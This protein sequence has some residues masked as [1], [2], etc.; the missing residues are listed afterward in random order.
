MDHE[1]TP[2]ITYRDWFKPIKGHTWDQC[3]TKMCNYYTLRDNQQCP[4]CSVIQSSKKWPR[5]E[6]LPFIVNVFALLKS[7]I[8]YK[9]F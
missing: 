4:I 5:K 9:Y 6:H 8:L 1:L 3:I 2:E 7:N